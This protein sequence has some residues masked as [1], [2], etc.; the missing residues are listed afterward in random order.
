MSRQME[1]DTLDDMLADAD[2]TDDAA[3]FHADDWALDDLDDGA[4]LASLHPAWADS[5]DRYE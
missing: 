5:R 4:D 1:F 2:D 3:D